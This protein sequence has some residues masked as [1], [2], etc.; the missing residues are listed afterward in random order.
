MAR[1]VGTAI[2]GPTRHESAVSLFR[3]DW[4]VAVTWQVERPGAAPTGGGTFMAR[5]L[6]EAHNELLAALQR[7]DVLSVGWVHIVEERTGQMAASFTGSVLEMVS[8]LT[9]SAAA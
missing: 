5:S 6:A 3:S 7:V 4:H 1:E 9:G 8:M 2:L